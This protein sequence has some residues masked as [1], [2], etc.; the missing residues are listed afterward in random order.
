MSGKKDHGICCLQA[1][2]LLR[3]QDCTASKGDGA[4]ADNPNGV[5]RGAVGG[6]IDDLRADR[7]VSYSVSELGS[8]FHNDLSR[9][10]ASQHY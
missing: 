2:S 4:I 1:L 5:L 7:F 8:S 10:F 9:Q 3:C 6:V